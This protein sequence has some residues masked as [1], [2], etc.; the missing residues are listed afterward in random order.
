MRKIFLNALDILS[1]RKSDVLIVSFPKTGNT[2]VRFF[3]CNYLLQLQERKERVDFGFLNK[4]MPEIGFNLYKRNDFFG[5]EVR[6]VKTHKKF[7]PFFKERKNVYIL[8]DPF[9]TI[10]SL[11]IYNQN[12]R[13]P[14]IKVESFSEFLKSDFGLDNYLRHYESWKE[15]IGLLVRFEDLRSE[16]NTY[17]KEII[18]YIGLPFDEQKMKRAIELADKKNIQ[19]LDDKDKNSGHKEK[20]KP[21]YVFAGDNAAKLKIVPTSNDLEFWNKKLSEYHFDLYPELSTHS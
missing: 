17:F 11:F 2:W 4:N 20:F 13:K 1:L 21:D 7:F 16:P 18:E 3:L 10:K 19:S 14:F 6:M 15:H 5:D 9:S 8:R 12:M